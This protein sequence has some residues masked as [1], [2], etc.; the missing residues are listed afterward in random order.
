[1]LVLKLYHN[2]TTKVKQEKNSSK[3]L[4]IKKS[5]LP[6]LKKDCIHNNNTYSALLQNAI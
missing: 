3:P 2:T 1:M 5:L 6:N 4:K